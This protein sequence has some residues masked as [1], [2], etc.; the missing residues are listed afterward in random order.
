MWVCYVYLVCG[1]VVVGFMLVWVFVI[2][3]GGRRGF[4]FVVFVFFCVLFL[5][6]WY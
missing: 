4:F 2:L 6:F 3:I 5:F 1:A